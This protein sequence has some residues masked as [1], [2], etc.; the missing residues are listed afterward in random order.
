MKSPSKQNPSNVHVRR[1]GCVRAL[2]STVLLIPLVVAA[3]SAAAQ[4]ARFNI[5]GNGNLTT[6]APTQRSGRFA[7][8]AQLMGPAARA[9]ESTTQANGRFALSAL[10]STSPLACYYDTI[11]RD[12]FDGTGL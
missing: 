11:F 1:H 9:Y 12:G 6:D 4:P 8:K 5:V 2:G 7:L 3:A 10:L